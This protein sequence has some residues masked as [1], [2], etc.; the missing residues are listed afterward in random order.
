MSLIVSHYCFQSLTVSSSAKGLLHVSPCVLWLLA[1]SN[2]LYG[3]IEL[4]HVSYCLQWF[5][6]LFDCLS[7]IMKLLY[8]SHC[9]L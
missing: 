6:A 2:C 3:P 8:V 7:G 5:L 9:L 4:L 1:A